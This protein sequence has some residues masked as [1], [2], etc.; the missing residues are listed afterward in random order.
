M[1]D[2]LVQRIIDRLRAVSAPPG[3][4]D[5]SQQELDRLKASQ[6]AGRPLPVSNMNEVD[7]MANGLPP[8][9]R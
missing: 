4:G 2:S 9:Q 1:S 7:R 5:L 6:A 3:Q 8:L